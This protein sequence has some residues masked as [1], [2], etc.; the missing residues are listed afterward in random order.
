MGE[1]V[2]STMGGIIRLFKKMLD[3]MFVFCA[4]S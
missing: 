3:I 4:T 2:E 1:Y